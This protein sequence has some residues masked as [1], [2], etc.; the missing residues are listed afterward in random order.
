MT[1]E[2]YVFN[3]DV[4]E[5][6][7]IKQGAIH[8][9]NGSKSKRCT[10]LSDYM[11]ATQKK[12]MNG[13][14]ET[15]CLNLPINSIK[16]LRTYTVSLQKEYLQNCITQYGARRIDLVNMLNTYDSTF[17][18]Y[19]ERHDILLDFLPKTG[20]GRSSRMDE[21]WL[22]FIT[23]PE[24]KQDIMPKKTDEQIIEEHFGI[25]LEPVE[26]TVFEVPVATESIEEVPIIEKTGYN[27][28]LKMKLDLK[29]SKEE[30]LYMM[31][32]ILGEN[33]NY[34][35]GINVVNAD[36]EEGAS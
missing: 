36:R 15:I 35:V 31:N 9:K 29:G 16:E 27:A 2:A 10:L 13:S 19:C 1:D 32:A 20:R 11:T 5:R 26:E 34:I 18:K 6:S 28:V 23:K 7:K 24:D 30:I 33:C 12:K 3:Q 22:D 25:K 4:R 17:K 21:R 14:V 8:K